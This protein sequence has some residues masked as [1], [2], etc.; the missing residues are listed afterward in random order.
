MNQE[1]PG[2][3][4][5]LGVLTVVLTLAGWTIVPIL[6]KEFTGDVDGWTSNG[7]RYGFAA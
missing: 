3:A 4:R 5:G 2:D 1:N 7:W 6:I